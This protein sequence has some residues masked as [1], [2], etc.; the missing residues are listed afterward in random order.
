MFA[1]RHNHPGRH[2]DS[3]GGPGR[4]AA[5]PHS[6]SLPERLLAIVRQRGGSRTRQVD[7][8][9]RHPRPQDVQERPAGLRPAGDVDEGRIPDERVLVIAHFVRLV[10]GMGPDHRGPSLQQS[11]PISLMG[12]SRAAKANLHV[13][14]ATPRTPV[15]LSPMTVETF[16]GVLYGRWN[17]TAAATVAR[18]HDLF[19]RFRRSGIRISRVGG[20]TRHLPHNTRLFRRQCR[21]LV[22]V[23]S[24]ER[25]DRNRPS[26]PISR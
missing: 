5:R 16:A 9:W 26:T 15:R 3:S 2:R 19:S 21:H 25:L 20:L 8:P 13:A 4:I 6:C 18:Y 24:G 7:V 14:T 11:S 22:L 17:R 10:V 1:W 23:R 12:R